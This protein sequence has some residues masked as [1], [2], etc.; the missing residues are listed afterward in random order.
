MAPPAGYM[1]CRGRVPRALG[2]AAAAGV[3]AAG[4]ASGLQENVPCEEGRIAHVF[5]DNH[6]IFDPS[7]PELDPRFAWA[8]RTANSLHARTEPEVIRRELLFEVGDCLDPFL[9][10]ESERLVRDLGFL[11]SVDVFSVRQPDGTQHVIVNT[12]DEWSTKVDIRADFDEGGVL[13]R[14]ARLAEENIA[15][16]GQAAG[17]FF[18]QDPELDS[19]DYGIAYS[20]PQAFGSRW[21]LGVEAGRTRVGHSFAYGIG[22][23]FV[24]EIGGTAAEHGLGFSERFFGLQVDDT[25]RVLIPM[26]SQHASI[27]VGRRF[28]SRGNLTIAGLA[29]LWT[30]LDYPSSLGPLLLAASG[31]EVPLADSAVAAV[32]GSQMDELHAVRVAAVFGRRSIRWVQRRGFD[33]MRALQDVALGAE[34]QFAVGRSINVLS[35]EDDVTT[36]VTFYAGGG[37]NDALFVARARADFRRELSG[38]ADAPEFIDLLAEGELLGYLR[39]GLEDRHT[40]VFR[41]AAEGGW[42]TAT[43]FQL[44]LG[45]EGGLRGVSRDRVPGGRRATVLL[46]DRIYFGW[47]W[48]DVLD[49]GASVFAEAGRM[50]AGD[51]PFGRDSEWNYTLGA[52]LRLAFPAGSRTTVRI[53]YAHPFGPDAGGGRILIEVREPFGAAVPFGSPQIA[54]SRRPGLGGA[55]FRF[56]N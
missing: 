21:D 40:L 45:S 32:V 5:I 7:D 16:S 3:C 42:N 28:G 56:R 10:A 48:R 1:R 54:R 27:G 2:V 49:A 41:A 47:P 11:T 53:D 35:E 29:L 25:S 55:L 43:P 31:A 44:T 15:G 30:D 51:A 6:S 26:R 14:G 20:T 46:E 23:P 34:L 22:H 38:A 19:R 39:P 18:R 50:W 36:A 52:G 17:V 37:G 12:R 24:G 33:T 8:Y 4:A 9:L 13:L